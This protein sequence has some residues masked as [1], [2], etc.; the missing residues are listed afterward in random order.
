LGGLFFGRHVVDRVYGFAGFEPVLY[1]RLDVAFLIL[2]KAW[3]IIDLPAGQR[4]SSGEYLV[5][6]PRC[7]AGA[8]GN[9]NPYEPSS[10]S[11]LLRQS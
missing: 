3:G 10:F 11:S 8:L 4:T 6:R 7:S 1:L 9:A 2:P 5:S